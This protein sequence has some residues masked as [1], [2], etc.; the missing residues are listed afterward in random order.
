MIVA[1]AR[2]CQYRPVPSCTC[3]ETDSLHYTT[4]SQ[5][6]SLCTQ[7]TS[8]TSPCHSLC[9]HRLQQAFIH[10]YIHNKTFFFNENQ[11]NQMQWHFWHP[12]SVVDYHH[13]WLWGGKVICVP[14]AL[15]ASTLAN[16]PDEGNQRFHLRTESFYAYE[17]KKIYGLHELAFT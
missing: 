15:P 10:F 9:H 14:V 2:Q 12:H 5:V 13:L 1:R 4:H 17:K 7:D 6:H 16:T 3:R 8:G 11:Y